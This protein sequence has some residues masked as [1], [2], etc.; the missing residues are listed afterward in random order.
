MYMYTNQGRDLL[1][2][3]R[4]ETELTSIVVGTLLVLVE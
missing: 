3:K 2:K 4:D 1:K